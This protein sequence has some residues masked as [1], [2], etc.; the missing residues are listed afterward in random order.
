MKAKRN[1][2]NQVELLNAVK[3][4]NKNKSMSDSDI[5][6]EVVVVKN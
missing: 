3:F 6:V 2:T 5:E 1:K 4:E